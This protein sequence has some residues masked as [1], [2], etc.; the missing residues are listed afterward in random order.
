[1]L[2]IGDAADETDIRLII[3][4]EVYTD[5]NFHMSTVLMDGRSTEYDSVDST[6]KN[7]YCET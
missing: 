7:K 4:G 3:V 6:S 1:M 2:V 5:H